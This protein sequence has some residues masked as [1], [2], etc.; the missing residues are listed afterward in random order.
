MSK[1]KNRKNMFDKFMAIFIC[2]IVFGLFA[3]GY[4]ME[5][6]ENIIVPV[7]DDLKAKSPSISL[8]K[9]VTEN[10]DII[11]PED[12]G[13]RITEASYLSTDSDEKIAL[14]VVHPDDEAANALTSTQE[15]SRVK[16]INV[17]TNGETNEITSVIINNPIKTISPLTFA[18]EETGNDYIGISNEFIDVKFKDATLKCKII[19]GKLYDGSGKTLQYIITLGKLAPNGERKTIDLGKHNVFPNSLDPLNTYLHFPARKTENGFVASF[20]NGYTIEDL[21]KYGYRTWTT[22]GVRDDY[23]LK[24][25]GEVVLPEEFLPAIYLKIPN[26]ELKKATPEA[27]KVT[28]PNFNDVYKPIEGNINIPSNGNNISEDIWDKINNK[29]KK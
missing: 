18:D 19:D 22:V 14:S 10:G 4:A 29:L 7:I 3:A 12:L 21:A 8:G 13:I 9:I 26:D 15:V 24:S 28:L 11:N 16:N 6:Y 2:V 5:I 27:E 23:I 20:P 25:D 1:K 17:T